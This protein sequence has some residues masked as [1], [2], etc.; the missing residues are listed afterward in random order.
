MKKRGKAPT[1]HRE[2]SKTE[3][4]KSGEIIE[5]T[6]TSHRKG[7]EIIEQVCKI[8]EQIGEKPITTPTTASM[9]QKSPNATCTT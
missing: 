7:W 2:R 3:S 5:K 9:K 6:E 4:N 1:H 8:V